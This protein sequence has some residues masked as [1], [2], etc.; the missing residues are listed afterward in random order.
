MSRFSL[1]F[2]SATTLVCATF[3]ASCS[4]AA[5][6]EEAAAAAATN[7]TPVAASIAEVLAE[8]ATAAAAATNETPVAASIAEVLAEP[9]TA[10]STNAIAVRIN[11]KDAITVAQIDE[12]VGRQLMAMANQ[13]DLQD[14][15]AIRP[16]IRE[17]AI[18]FLINDYLLNDIIS[19][20]TSPVSEEDRRNLVATRFGPD[21]PSYEELS[22]QEGFLEVLDK[23]VRLERL[24][25]SKT[26]GLPAVTDAE[27]KERFDLVIQQ[28]PEAAKR[29]EL[30][31]AS[32]ILVRVDKDAPEADVKAAQ[33][34]I[35][36]IRE[37][38]LAGGDFAKLAA[39]HSDCP[40][41]KGAGGSLGE[42]GRGR[43]VKEFEDAAFTQEVD[44]IGE[45]VRT[46][47]GFHIIKVTQHTPAGETKFEDV[48]DSIVY[49]MT[50]ERAMEAVQNY[51]DSLRND[52]KVE[53]LIDDVVSAPVSADPAAPA[54]ESAPEA[55]PAWAE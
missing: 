17:R 49:G 39:E 31:T 21:A 48:R 11:G 18:T 27:A 23:N 16:Q 34:K 44:V 25:T 12:F 53:I 45:P 41:G 50:Q 3:C 46:D 35:T 8:P 15:P 28:N 40:S 19:K 52:A 55:L 1:S 4:K 22:K 32:H 33:E 13:I 51:F 7:E 43:M 5:P 37:E 6:A 26:N 24:L 38:L 14:I 30:V 20:D 47:F 9:A 36:K 10:A 2:L 54:E 29:P 42:F